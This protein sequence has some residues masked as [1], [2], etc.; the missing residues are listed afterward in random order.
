MIFRKAIQAGGSH[1]ILFG[2]DSTFF[3]RGWRINV[4]EAQVKACRELK[5]DGVINDTDI[6]NIFHDNIM[7]LAK[8]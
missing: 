5:V 4:L 6:A 8:L 2:T 3:P 1:K 7:R